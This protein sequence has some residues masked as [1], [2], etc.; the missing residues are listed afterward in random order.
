MQINAKRVFPKLTLLVALG[1]LTPLTHADSVTLNASN[2]GYYNFVGFSNGSVGNIAQIG[3]TY[4]S[5]LGFDLS[6]VG[7][8][9]TS[10]TLQVASEPRNSSGQIINWWDVSTPYSQL[11]TVGGAAGIGIF[12]DL[13]GGSLFAQGIHTAG[14]LNSFTLNSSALAALNAADSFWAIGGANSEA[15]LAFAYQNGISSQQ[16]IR[17]VLDVQGTNVP[18]GGSTIIALGVGIVGL[19]GSRRFLR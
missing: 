11:G 6:G 16:T 3:E 1:T 12:N 9:I 17:L 10:A 14:G 13:G 7:G 4:R 8:T 2:S 5:W 19:L 18:D 15:N